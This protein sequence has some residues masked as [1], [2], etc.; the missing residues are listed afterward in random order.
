[1]PMETFS[2]SSAPVWTMLPCNLYFLPFT[3]RSSGLCV[4]PSSSHFPV[5]CGTRSA[6]RASMRASGVPHMLKNIS[7]PQ[8]MRESSSRNT[9][10]GIGKFTSALLLEFSVS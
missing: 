2:A 5:N 1:M 7:F 10:I 9:A 6:T 8:I 3:V 4:L